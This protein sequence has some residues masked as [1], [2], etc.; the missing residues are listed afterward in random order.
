MS[1]L[2]R[3]IHFLFISNPSFIAYNGTGAGA[4]PVSRSG[5][6]LHLKENL[7]WESRSLPTR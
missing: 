3:K 2:L 5:C 4:A 6:N 7:H 1:K